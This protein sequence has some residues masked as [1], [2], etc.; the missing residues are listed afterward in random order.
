M[1]GLSIHVQLMNKS[2]VIS[3]MGKENTKK[4]KPHIFRLYV[5]TELPPAWADPQFSV[6]SV[7]QAAPGVGSVKTGSGLTE[8]SAEPVAPSGGKVVSHAPVAAAVEPVTLEGKRVQSL[9]RQTTKQ[10]DM[11]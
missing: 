1:K 11:E 3:D 5:R 10:R 6:S 2:E 9:T 4:K 7:L 8:T